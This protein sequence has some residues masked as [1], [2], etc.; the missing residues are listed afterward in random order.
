[1]KRNVIRII[2]GSIGV[3]CAMY[4]LW[5]YDNFPTGGNGSLSQSAALQL[6]RTTGIALA[7][8]AGFLLTFRWITRNPPAG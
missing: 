5:L 4:A 7:A 8:F 2:L 1:M 3:L 6:E